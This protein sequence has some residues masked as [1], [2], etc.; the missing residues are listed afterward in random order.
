MDAGKRQRE[1]ARN[2][3]ADGTKT[4]PYK[5]SNSRKDGQRSKR[6]G[7]G[8]HETTAKRHLKARMHET[9]M[10]MEKDCMSELETVTEENRCM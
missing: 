8:R 7:L 2:K 10:E 6:T 1:R 3:R 9:G 5:K 4:D